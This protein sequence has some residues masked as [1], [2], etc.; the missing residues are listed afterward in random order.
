MLR[1]SARISVA[2]LLMPGVASAA[3]TAVPLADTARE[4]DQKAV[5]ALLQQRVDVNAKEPD[6]ST[7]LHWA[8]HRGDLTT[9]DLLLKAGARA[10]TA[11]HYGA[12]PLS[13]AAATES[14]S[15]VERLL[16]AGASPNTPAPGG[17]T[18]LMTAARTGRTAVVRSLIEHG[19]DVNARESTR[20]QTALMWAAAEGYADVV[21][22]LL[23]GGADIKAQSKGPDVPKNITSGTSIYA[24]VAPR[25]DIFTPL[26]FAVQAGQIEATRVL[27]EAGGSLLDETPQRMSLLTLAIANAH[28]ELAAVLLDQGADVHAA[29]VGF[30]P[31]HQVVRMRTLNIGQFPHP[32]QTGKLDSLDVARMLLDYG[33]EADARIKKSFTDGW[34]NP[35]GAGFTPFLM[36]AKGGDTKMMRLLAEYGADVKATDNGGAN[37]LMLA[38][39]VGMFNNNED[40]GTDADCLAALKVAFELGVGDINATNRNGDSAL[41]GA[42]N[43]TSNDII[44]FLVDHGAK[45]DVKNKRGATPIQMTVNGVGAVSGERPEAEAL[46]RKLMIER[47]LNPEVKVNQNKYSFGVKVN[48]GPDGPAQPVAK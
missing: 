12:T 26:Q 46:L 2:V 16:K 28:F 23:K 19:A 40:S 11:T 34:R 44:Q 24:R 25:V 7:A 9:V 10:E 3:G 31:L 35:P 37:A 32:L 43:R 47:G 38:A 20:N 22:A 8:A 15:V 18:A 33:A 17:E 21:R 4:G 5:R 36:A 14:E 1:W 48:N 45:L 42:V 39:G 13:L 29:D 6:G 41:H 30:S 27:L